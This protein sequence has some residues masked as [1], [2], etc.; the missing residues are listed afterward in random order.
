MDRK[1]IL[2]KLQ[3][4]FS[5]KRNKASMKTNIEIINVKSSFF[6]KYKYLMQPICKEILIFSL[7]SN[8]MFVKETVK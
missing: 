7:Y 3:A 6:N 2:F 5:D 1:I 8:I 4:I